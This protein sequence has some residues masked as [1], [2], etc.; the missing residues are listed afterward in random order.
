MT[1]DRQAS[2]QARFPRASPLQP[3]EPRREADLDG[4]ARP[5]NGNEEAAKLPLWLNPFQLV[6]WVQ[7]RDATIAEEAD[8]HTNL[9]AKTFFRTVGIV[10]DKEE[11]LEAL[12]AG[13]LKSYGA[14]LQGKMTEI[15]AIE[16][17]RIDLAPLEPSRQHPYT[18]IRFNRDD[19]VAVFP[20]TE[21]RGDAESNAR[22]ARAVIPRTI[23]PALS[24][25]LQPVANPESATER[26]SEDGSADNSEW[27]G[28]SKAIRILHRIL[29]TRLAGQEP[30]PWID[31]PDNPFDAECENA[32]RRHRRTAR[33]SL[34]MRRA[35]LAGELTAHLVKDGRS[36]PLPGWA[37]E[38]A[39]AAENAFNFNW[40]PLNPLLKH[41]LGE[42]DDWRCFVSRAEFQAWLAR[43]D[44]VEIGNL[45]TL[46]APF[47]HEVQPD[48]LS[49]RE[50]PD[51]PFVELTQALTWIAFAVSLSCDELGFMESCRF[52]PFA[53]SG[54]PDGLRTAMA[55]F[56]VQ[57]S[58]GNIRVRGRY[59]ANYSNHTAVSQTDTAYL[60]DTQLRDFACFDSLH[61]GLERGAGLAWETDV[62]EQALNGR[63]DGWRDVEV[64]R[65][66]V[67]RVFDRED[68]TVRALTQP[69]PASLPDIGSVMGLDEALSW[70]AHNRPSYDYQV[71]ADGAGE[72]QI[73]DPSGEVVE[74]AED[75]SP[76]QS[77]EDLR[78]ASRKLHGVLRDG[79]LA[80]YVAP[81]GG[82]P[83]QVPRAYWNRVNPESLHHVYRGMTPDDQGAEC[84]V[85]LSRKAFDEW[86]NGGLHASGE[87]SDAKGRAPA[88]K[89]GRPPSE[90]EIL[91]KADEMKARGLDG[92]TLAKMMRHE[93]G[94][95]HVATTEVRELIRGRYKPGGRPRR[96]GA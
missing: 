46:P 45:P 32:T 73:R 96:K 10:G 40:L 36:H 42:F 59:V 50:P 17:T 94:F 68:D 33:T 15:E 2:R 55:H 76:P 64:C 25:K 20:P 92:R 3:W 71:W 90:E 27:L 61:G 41:G 54:W 83:L 66:D 7:Y 60:S 88:V 77:I 86:R 49:Y 91:A 11:A 4:D 51:R 38:N 74:P 5:K 81:E 18:S 82:S 85:L 21:G 69:I 70:L 9:A 56:C 47:D 28:I 75:G 63:N 80:T 44:I 31:R 22:G 39:R 35:L 89:K 24:E 53:E 8:T 14:E 65:A 37:W 48:Q 30:A 93:P 78:Q 1:G 67:M 95:E 26:V 16:W 13:Q 84:P 58:A 12:Q 57:A 19:V 62:L 34:T 29:R 6:A 79:S 72:I 23:E 87:E 52:G 43:P